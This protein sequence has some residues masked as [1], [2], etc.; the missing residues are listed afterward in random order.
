MLQFLLRV[1]GLFLFW[2]GLAHATQIHLRPVG[3]VVADGK[4]EATLH[5]WVPHLEDGDKVKALDVD[6][7]YE[8]LQERMC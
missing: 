3:P 1:S 5:I 8:A 2:L 4:E 7:V 6:S